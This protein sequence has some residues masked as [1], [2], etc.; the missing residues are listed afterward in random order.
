MGSMS[1]LSIVGLNILIFSATI[2]KIILSRIGFGS[3]DGKYDIGQVL[4]TL[5]PG[6]FITI[7]A[8]GFFFSGLTWSTIRRAWIV[9]GSA[10]N[11]GVLMQLLFWYP[12]SG[13]QV[14]ELIFNSFV[15]AEFATVASAL[16]WG[17]YEPENVYTPIQRKPLDDL[18]GVEAK[19]EAIEKKIVHLKALAKQEP[20]EDRQQKSEAPETIRGA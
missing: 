1:A 16:I 9:A 17:E 2:I 19:L 20:K 10:L 4:G 6:F 3:R 7:T 15:L 14:F 12:Q 18:K 13:L 11:F 5:I 8:L